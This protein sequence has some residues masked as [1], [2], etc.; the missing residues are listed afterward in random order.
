MRGK[1]ALRKTLPVRG[2]RIEVELFRR[3]AEGNW[4][5]SPFIVRPPDTLELT[6]IGFATP[7]ADLYRTAGL[8]R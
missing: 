2:S 4:P 8:S 1:A 5:D 3:D 6:S 7:V